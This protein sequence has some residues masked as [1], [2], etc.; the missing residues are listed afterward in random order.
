MAQKKRTASVGEMAVPLVGILVNDEWRRVMITHL[1]KR[2]NWSFGD[3]LTFEGYGPVDGKRRGYDTV[4]EAVGGFLDWWLR[5]HE[6]PP[7]QIRWVVPNDDVVAQPT[8]A[9]LQALH[10]AEHRKVHAAQ[11]HI[12]ELETEV[13][14]LWRA[15]QEAQERPSAAPPA[16]RKGQG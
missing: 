13:A 16:D 14:R 8:Y 5:T 10:D 6:E 9:E 1:Q 3:V 11:E 15:L 4:G 7:P 2:F 12:K